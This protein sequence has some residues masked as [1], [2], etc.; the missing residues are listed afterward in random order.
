MGAVSPN[1]IQAL[2]D[3]LSFLGVANASL[4]ST[5]LDPIAMAEI[6]DADLILIANSG[7]LP[8]DIV[9]MGF[10]GNWLA[11]T[12]YPGGTLVVTPGGGIVV[13]QDSGVVTGGSYAETGWNRLTSDGG[14]IGGGTALLSNLTTPAS[15]AIIFQSKRSGD[16]FPRAIF[17]DDQYMFLDG[18]TDPAAIRAGTSDAAS[19]KVYIQGT[20]NHMALVQSAG[21]TDHGLHSITSVLDFQLVPITWTSNVGGVWVNDGISTTQSVFGPT[22][23][24]EDIY[25]YDTRRMVASFRHAGAPGNQFDHQTATGTTFQG[26]RGKNIGKWVSPGAV[27]GITSIDNPF[28]GWVSPG[29]TNELIQFKQVAAGSMSARSATAGTLSTWIPCVAGNFAKVLASLRGVST[30]RTI[31]PAVAFCDSSGN[32]LGT[33]VAGTP[34]SVGVGS[35]A[36]LSAGS[37]APSGARGYA[38]QFTATGM[39]ANEIQYYSG[40]G[41]WLDTNTSGAVDQNPENLYSPPYTAQQVGGVWTSVRSGDLYYRTD[42][43]ATPGKRIYMLDGAANTLYLPSQVG[44]PGSPSQPRWVGIDGALTTATTIPSSA[45]TTSRTLVIGDAG[46]CIDVNAGSG[47]SLTVPPNASVPYPVGTIIEFYQVGAGSVTLAQGSGVVLQN[48]SSLV[49]R[50]Q[51]ST[52]G[53]RYRGGDVWAVSGDL[54]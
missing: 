23:A 35:W 9:P 5:T 3:R 28:G 50:A 29:E 43:A 14:I 4:L 2:F 16:A 26:D 47:V 39:S 12:F 7:H 10:G 6:S 8:P 17:Y 13:A 15:G 44:A 18:A 48:A 46:T 34:V 45:Q 38:L 25:G 21:S 49:T 42:Q 32:V 52:I 20:D 1:Q 24:N 40:G 51:F 22:W 53:I 33:P 41:G 19:A 36:V 54:A 30:T 31:T 11:N 27:T 37:V